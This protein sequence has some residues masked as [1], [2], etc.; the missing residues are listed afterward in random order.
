MLF[1]DPPYFDKNLYRYDFDDD[2]HERLARLLK[3]TP[4]NWL[5]THE[6]HPA[7]WELYDGWAAITPLYKSRLVHFDPE[8]RVAENVDTLPISNRR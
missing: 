6:D 2:D 8:T 1:I 7:V 4:H 5:V 3:E